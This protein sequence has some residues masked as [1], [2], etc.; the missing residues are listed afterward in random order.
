MLRQL[1]VIC[2]PLVDE[3]AEAG[4]SGYGGGRECDA[5]VGKGW[6]MRGLPSKGLCREVDVLSHLW[7]RV[8]NAIAGLTLGEELWMPASRAYTKRRMGVSRPRLESTTGRRN[9]TVNVS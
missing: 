4:V 8:V 7:L 3:A 6:V 9:Q 1:G 2:A 5:S